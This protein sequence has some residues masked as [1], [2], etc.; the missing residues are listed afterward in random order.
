MNTAHHFDTVTIV[1]SGIMGAGI[2]QV[3]AASTGTTVRLCDL[4]P[5]RLDAAL[6]RIEN[7]RFGLRRSADRGKIS[8]GDV[9]AIMARIEAH[10]DLAAACAATDLV[11]EAIPEDLALKCRLFRQLDDLCPDHTVLTSN[12]AGLPITAMAWATQRPE[13]VVGWHW[14]QPTAVIKLAEIV[15]HADT[16]PRVANRVCSFATACG[17][18][19]EKINDNPFAWGFVANRIFD[20]AHKEALRVVEEGVATAGQVDRILKDSY[21]WPV[22]PL[23][24]R[25]QSSFE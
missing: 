11:I 1:G 2:A 20:A 7:G 12:T 5:A 10:T 6:D 21:R 9:A 19:P 25:S 8:V 24:M 17:K 14:A 3:V 13:K 16:D 18:H 23:E 22:G 15:I 4:D